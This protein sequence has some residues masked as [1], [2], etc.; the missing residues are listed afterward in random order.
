MLDLKLLRDRPDFLRQALANRQGKIDLD[1][2]IDLDRQQRQLSKA[3]SELQADSNSIGKQVGSAIKAGAD[4]QGEEVAALRQKGSD[5]RKEVVE[6]EARER[7]VA[8]QLDEWLLTVP[9][10]PQAVVPI[11]Q[12]EEDNVEVRRWGR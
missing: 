6:L 2:A 1:V 4:P 7:E 11:G 5:L 3:R 8:E 12:S 9:N 10:P